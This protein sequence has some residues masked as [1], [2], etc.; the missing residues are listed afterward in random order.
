MRHDLY[1]HRVAEWSNASHLT[2]KEYTLKERPLP[3]NAKQYH[4][5]LTKEGRVI[6][7]YPKVAKKRR[8]EVAAANGVEKRMKFS[9]K[10]AEPIVAVRSLPLPVDVNEGVDDVVEAASVE[11]L[12]AGLDTSIDDFTLTEMFQGEDSLDTLISGGDVDDYFSTT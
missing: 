10:T 4:K 12:L 1:V 6:A 11:E 7:P 2:T 3:F 8:V 5:G 9:E